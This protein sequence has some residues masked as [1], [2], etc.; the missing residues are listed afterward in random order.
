MNLVYTH[1]E[2]P[3]TLL[4][5]YLWKHFFASLSIVQGFVTNIYNVLNLETYPKTVI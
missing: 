1:P 4:C 3:N 5:Y 2:G